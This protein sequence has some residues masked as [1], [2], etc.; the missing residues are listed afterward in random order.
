MCVINFTSDEL[1][2]LQNEKCT[3]E[4]LFVCLRESRAVCQDQNCSFPSRPASCLKGVLKP[5]N[6]KCCTR[7]LSI[8]NYYLFRCGVRQ[9]LGKC[10]VE[11]NC[12]YSLCDEWISAEHWWS[13]TDS[14]EEKYSV[15]N[16][17]QCHMDWPGIKHGSVGTEVYRYPPEPWHGL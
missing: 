8:E 4:G 7:Q 17:S 9:C 11:Q 16:L 13:H 2:S 3:H 10:G 1:R 14:R 5:D 6:R 12:L 15:T